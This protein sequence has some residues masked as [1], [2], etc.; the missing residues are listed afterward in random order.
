M[1][2]AQHQLLRTY[3]GMLSTALSIQRD[4]ASG[5]IT[6]TAATLSSLVRTT[7]NS[8]LDAINAAAEYTSADDVIDIEEQ[9]RQLKSEMQQASA[10]TS[11]SFVWKDSPLVE[12]LRNGHMV[13]EAACW[14][15][16]AS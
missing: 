13:G 11:T 5:S 3:S 7:V 6:Y 12:A 4:L 14:E 16:Y 10:H 15:Q 8:V 2:P 9:L 1:S